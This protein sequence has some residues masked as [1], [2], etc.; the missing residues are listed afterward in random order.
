[1]PSFLSDDTRTLLR[2]AKHAF[3]AGRYFTCL[4]CILLTPLGRLVRHE[5]EHTLATDTY[6]MF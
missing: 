5:E 4:I 3:R 1:M 6:V 2:P